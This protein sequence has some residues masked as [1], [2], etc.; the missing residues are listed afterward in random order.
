MH[1]TE[2]QK[3]TGRT[4]KTLSEVFR[5]E[6]LTVQAWKKADGG[7]TKK[8]TAREF[9][10]NRVEN[11]GIDHTVCLLF[12]WKM[13]QFYE[14]TGAERV[15]IFCLSVSSILKYHM[16]FS[17]QISSFP[18]WVSDGPHTGN[19]NKGFVLYLLRKLQPGETCKCVP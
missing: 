9:K 18:E 16:M 10:N 4:Q 8:G 19:H 2:W 5:A 15:N 6:Q 11:K 12:V 7:A 3:N 1:D 13:S 14:E 17:P